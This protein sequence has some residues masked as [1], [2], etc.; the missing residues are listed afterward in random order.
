MISVILPTYNRASLL[1]RAMRSVLEQTY[2]DLELVVVDDASTDDTARVVAEINDYRVRYVCQEKNKG[3]CAARNRGIS[4]ARGEY[5]AFQDSD[6]TWLPDKLEKQLRRMEETGADIVFCGFRR[7][8]G[9]KETIFPPETLAE[10]EVTYDQL[11]LENLIST[12]TI[13]GKRQCF[14]EHPFDE[15]FPRMQDWELVLRLVQHCRIHYMAQPLADVYLQKDSISRKP[16][17]GFAALKKLLEMHGPALRKNDMAARRFAVAMA[18]MTSQCGRNPAKAYLRLV[19]PTLKFR[20]NLYL[21]AHS[22]R[23]MITG[24]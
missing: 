16:E 15:S 14:V 24:R 6:D 8:S 1:P 18:V 21:L 20:T 10:G 12:Q 4:M 7:F 3:A 13:L 2:Q 5:I 19:S 22:V 17:A 11:L 9:N 23:A